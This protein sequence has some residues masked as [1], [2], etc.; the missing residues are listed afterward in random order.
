[1][2]SRDLK[3]RYLGDSKSLT[4]ASGRAKKS[5]GGVDRQARTTG[6]GLG[7]MQG[8]VA[9]LGL[10]LGG[11]VLIGGAK[12]AI[13]RA[14]E[15]G[16]AYAAT[17]AIITA[18]GGAA[19][20]TGGQ[21]KGMAA[22]MSL[23]TGVDKAL[24]IEGQNLLLT[25]KNIKDEVGE[26]N[27]V[28]SRTQD[29]MLDLAAVMKTDAK[30][31]AL[32][33]GKAL[34]DPIKGVS[35]LQRIGVT[36]TDVQKEQIRLFVEAGDV[37]AAQGV[38]LD[39][40]EGQVGGVAEATADSTAKIS[41]AWKEVQEQIGNVLLPAIDALVPAMQA[42]GREAPAA[43]RKIGLG[44]SQVTRQLQG[45]F[46]L[47]DIAAG[48]FINLDDT[49][50]SNQEIL[51]QVNKRMVQYTESLAAGGDESNLFVSVLADLIAKGDFWT[52]SLKAM[53]EATGISGDE[54]KEAALFA[55]ANAEALG[56]N[57]EAA[58][59]LKRELKKLEMGTSDMSTA[60]GDSVGPLGD[61]ADA[62]GDVEQKGK[63]A[64][65]AVDGV[66]EAMKKLTDPVFRAE[67]A[68]DKF[69]E[70]LARVQDD[71]VLTQDEL[72]ELTEDL[73]AMRVANEAVT[74]ANLQAYGEA[75]REALGLV[76][77]ATIRTEGRLTA[78]SSTAGAEMGKF[79]E[80]ARRA[81]TQEL[82]VKITAT[83]PSRAT[84]DRLVREA[85]RRT[86]RGRGS[87]GGGLFQ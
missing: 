21:I 54:F 51:F 62:E 72:E 25:F 44:F 56:I 32:Q 48:P 15:M 76:D 42:A 57:E 78:L 24:I 69:N 83:A 34:N 71:A 82:R 22:E 1:M 58:D 17:E 87:G 4:K 39:E 68:T 41:N 52:G 60:A 40:L 43:T 29:V 73:V 67:S 86:G 47:A 75:S 30:S 77:E 64:K 20:L 74:P 81:A 2:P 18:T 13:N 3:F 70:T 9:K 10:L 33:L 84:M 19:G 8:G 65:A 50:T 23:A 85:I 6:K 12:K 5:L 36:F 26:G 7:I 28:F 63:A 31:S 14:E 27:N 11:A 16:S 79:V 35:Q 45:L 80:L 66:A 53:I 46:D 59:L 61:M 38:I 55:L 37:A 49:W